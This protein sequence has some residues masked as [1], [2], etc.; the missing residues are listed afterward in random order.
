MKVSNVK[1]ILCTL[2][3]NISIMIERLKATVELNSNLRKGGHAAAK[4]DSCFGKASPMSGKGRSA[5]SRETFS[6]TDSRSRLGHHSRIEDKGLV[7]SF[8]TLRED[9][10]E[11]NFTLGSQLD[12]VDDC[13]ND[14]REMLRCQQ[15]ALC[16]FREFVRGLEKDQTYYCEEIDCLRDENVKLREDIEQLDS[17]QQDYYIRTRS[18]VCRLVRDNEELLRENDIGKHHINSLERELEDLR[19]ERSSQRVELSANQRELT[20]VPL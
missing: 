17:T 10:L 13:L 16:H 12:R 1:N 19:I 2:D 7:S 3:S 14:F 6:G 9:E 4:T 8:K 15:N 20:E 11:A 5:A 18:D